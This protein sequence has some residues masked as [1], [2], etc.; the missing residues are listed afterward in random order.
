M[1]KTEPRTAIIT[2]S[3]KEK[4]NWEQYLDYTQFFEPAEINNISQE[5]FKKDFE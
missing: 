1:E 5:F 2:R 4:I 3:E